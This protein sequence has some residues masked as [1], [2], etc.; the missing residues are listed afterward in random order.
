MEET[1]ALKVKCPVCGAKAGTGCSRVELVPG[2]DNRIH[3]F[4]GVH[5]LRVQVGEAAK[6]KKERGL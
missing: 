6:E 5:M 1:P 2:R 4:L 3:P